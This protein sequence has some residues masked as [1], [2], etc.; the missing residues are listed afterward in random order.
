MILNHSHSSILM[1]NIKSMTK[2]LNA[3]IFRY[4]IFVSLSF[5]HS[6]ATTTTSFAPCITLDQ[7]SMGYEVSGYPAFTSTAGECSNLCN[8]NS[9]CKFWRWHSESFESTGWENPK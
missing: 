6:K 5:P 7:Q 8:D 4:T 2:A 3:N 1:E 9:D